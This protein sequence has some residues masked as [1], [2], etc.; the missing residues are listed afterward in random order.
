MKPAPLTRFFY[1]GLTT[2]VPLLAAIWCALV[3][4]L[5]QTCSWILPN[6]SAL[7]QAQYTTHVLVIYCLLISI[8]GLVTLGAWAVLDYIRARRDPKIEADYQRRRAAANHQP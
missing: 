3:A 5:L 7:T 1:L 2:V 4:L 8:P 6:P